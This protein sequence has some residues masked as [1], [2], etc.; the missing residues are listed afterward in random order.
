MSDHSPRW[1][2]DTPAIRAGLV[3]DVLCVELRGRFTASRLTASLVR[4]RAAMKQRDYGALIINVMRA[5]LNANS[6]QLAA[7]WQAPKDCPLAARPCAIVY[8]AHKVGTDGLYE[9]LA[10]RLADGQPAVIMGAFDVGL[11]MDATSWAARRALNFRDEAARREMRASAHRTSD[12]PL[13]KPA[14]G[15]RRS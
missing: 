8:D 12:K 13:R 9:A 4:L 3:Q 14:T 10:M 2:L 1:V 7:L 6:A 15:P 5:S 11:L